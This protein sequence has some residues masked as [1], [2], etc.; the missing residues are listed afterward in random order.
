MY[1]SSHGVW[2]RDII[3]TD[4]TVF[5]L[6]VCRLARTSCG[7]YRGSYNPSITS[8]ADTNL[9]LVKDDLPGGSV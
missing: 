7:T 6:E 1:G 2:T 3:L 8:D 9:E 5:L 4:E